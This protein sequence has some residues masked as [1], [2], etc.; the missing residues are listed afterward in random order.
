MT[1]FQMLA[2]KIGTCPARSIH[3]TPTVY[4][5]LPHGDSVVCSPFSLAQ[6]RL[7]A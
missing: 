4:E 2:G 6:D 3:P 1:A 5:L 7:S